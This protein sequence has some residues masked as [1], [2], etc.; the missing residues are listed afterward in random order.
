VT[1]PATV[2]IEE[3]VHLSR[4]NSPGVLKLIKLEGW[5][6]K[7]LIVTLSNSSLV[8]WLLPVGLRQLELSGLATPGWFEGIIQNKK[9]KGGN[10]VIIFNGES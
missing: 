8:A 3:I 7:F 5:C 4:T 10:E 9:R 2:E 6:K 1:T